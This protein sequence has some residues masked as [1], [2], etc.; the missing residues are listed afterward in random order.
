MKFKNTLIAATLL[1]SITSA[2]A[3]LV[4]SDWQ[5]TGDA[6]ATLDT[7]TGIEWL[8]LTQTSNMSINQVEGLTGN[9]STFDGWRL[10]TRAEVAQMMMS[11]F[12]SETS[13]VQ[14]DGVWMINNATFDNET[15]GF[16]SLF[17][18]THE[19]SSYQFTKAMF[20]NDDQENGEIALTSGA[21]DKKVDNLVYFYSN[22]DNSLNYDYVSEKYSVYLVSDGGTTLSSINDPSMNANNAAAPINNVSAPA[23]LGLMGLGL[24]G[25]AARRR[26][27]TP[28]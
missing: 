23:L 14:S 21:T 22:H 7:D 6:L 1:L 24:F 12:S 11:A 20:K 4:G 25:F 9:G 26:S 19:N 2:Q 15:D 28:Y 18:L 5:N 16:R 10:P 3:A 27:S 8:D 17:G 13:K